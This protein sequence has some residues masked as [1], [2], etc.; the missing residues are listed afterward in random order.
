MI[1]IMRLSSVRLDLGRVLP[2]A[3]LVLCNTVSAQ[4][5]TFCRTYAGLLPFGSG[6]QDVRGDSFGAF[7]AA[8]GWAVPTNN[9]QMGLINVQADGSVIW[10][11][12]ALRRRGL[13]APAID[14]DALLV[15]DFE[16]YLHWLDKSTGEIVARRKT[17]G[18]RISNAAI[19]DESR[20][21]VQTDSGKLI[22]LS[23]RAREQRTADSGQ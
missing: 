9:Y 13:T 1:K 21:F 3:S 18:E 7:L 8:G 19:A 15:G 5:Q 22:A 23:S 12:S 4:T 14:G 2:F 6:I 20:T 17:D 10:E 16:G 11:Q